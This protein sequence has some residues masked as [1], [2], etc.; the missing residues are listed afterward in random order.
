MKN[1]NY[2]IFDKNKFD[3]DPNKKT[4]GIFGKGLTN[5]N[6]AAPQ[7]AMKIVGELEKTFNVVFFQLTAEAY[8]KNVFRFN[9]NFSK[10]LLTKKEDSQATAKNEK[11]IRDEILDAMKTIHCIFDHILVIGSFNLPAQSFFRKKENPE[12]YKRSQNYYDIINEEQYRKFAS[13]INKT[14]H[15]ISTN[16]SECF[17]PKAF[18]LKTTHCVYFTIK[19]LFENRLLKEKVILIIDDPETFYPFYREN[20]IPHKVFYWEN[21]FR[22]SREF[23]KYNHGQISHIIKNKNS[24]DITTLFET[25]DEKNTN[26]KNFIF[27]GTIFHNFDTPRNDIWGRFLKDF[28]YE[29]SNFFIPLKRSWT[30]LYSAH[31]ESDLKVLKETHESLLDEVTKHPLFSPQEEYPITKKTLSK[32][33]YSFVARCTSISDSLN[34][35]PIL[36]VYSGVLPLLDYLYDPDYLQIPKEIADQLIVHDHIEM[37]ERIDYFEKNRNKVEEILWKLRILFDIDNWI[38]NPNQML[39]NEVQKLFN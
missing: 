37:K 18:T 19:T 8:T 35:R 27:Y 34:L 9:F 36:Y 39:T 7:Y 14:S 26:Y 2:F 33:K 5:P 38:N 30:R 29:N 12:L 31:T 22:G 16:I 32:Y 28:D 15:R 10:K 20:N 23:Y 11:L 17:N 1:D 21:D 25:E 13:E 4:I 3:L 6:A 24:N